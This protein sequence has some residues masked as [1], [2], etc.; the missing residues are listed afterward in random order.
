[1]CFY[2]IFIL[3]FTIYLKQSVSLDTKYLQ[4]YKY[5]SIKKPMDQQ[6]QRILKAL[7][8]D[9]RASDNAISRQTAIPV[10]TV[11]RKRKLLEQSNTILYKTAINPNQHGLFSQMYVIKLAEGITRQQYDKAMNASP[12]ARASHARFIRHAYLGEKDGHLTVILLLEA[13][14]LSELTDQFN[15]KLVPFFKQSLGEA[16]LVSIETMPILHTIREDTNYVLDV[17][18]YQAKLTPTWPSEFITVQQT[19]ATF[20][21]NNQL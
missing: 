6:T 3:I 1:V 20:L 13:Q 15:A 21:K 14:T 18:V 9:P 12:I 5:K 11:N 2:G 19:N 8:V 16:S 17:N 7:I 10:V 4:L